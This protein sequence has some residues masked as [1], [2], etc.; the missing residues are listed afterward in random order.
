MSLATLSPRMRLN[1][2]IADA[3]IL[4]LLVAGIG[5]LAIL[6]Q[7]L[8]MP[9][10]D[11]AWLLTVADRMLDGQRLYVDVIETNP[12]ASVYLYWPAA[13]L[14]RILP[15]RAEV[16]VDAMVLAAI[17]GSLWFCAGT[18]RALPNF[19][20][21]EHRRMLVST[22]AIL[23]LLPAAC[24][25]ERE[26]IALI[27]VLPCLC[28]AT[29]RGHAMDI[30]W[31]RIIVT[32]LCG[33]LA[34]VIKPHFALALAPVWLLVSLTRA[35]WRL[36]FAP[37]V[38][39]AG[40]V[41]VAYATETLIVHP[42]FWSGMMPM[43]AAVYLPI[44]YPP[45]A[46][47][48]QFRDLMVGFAGLLT[49]SAW[50]GWKGRTDI[51]TLAGLAGI[52]FMAATILQGKGMPYH[53]YPPM[54]LALLV[55]LNVA[56]PRPG[57]GPAATSLLAIALS[58]FCWTWFNAGFDMR[59]L[60]APV[61]SAAPH[62]RVL[63]LGYDFSAGPPVARAAG[64][65]YIGSVASQW[66]ADNVHWLLEGPIAPDERAR[67]EA[68]EMRDRDLFVADLQTKPDVLLV[69]R[70]PQDWLDWARRDPRF[71]PAF[72]GYRQSGSYNSAGMRNGLT[73]GYDMFVRQTAP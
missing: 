25:G 55:A 65:T 46:F 13:A 62:A 60:I 10:A 27:A 66:T 17:A 67:L 32:G 70:T 23:M 26:H 45:L 44:R 11:I 64:G 73:L 72:A 35:D 30:P 40:T 31:P 28:I 3:A 52:G 33:G 15:L 7:A 5:M 24:F 9:N 56:S 16:I 38:L 22:S 36:L 49:L 48:A 1:S 21:N 37:E 69:Q 59:A 20:A 71:G 58:I 18:L 29:L 19:T 8:V 63:A 4:P 43:L 34:L 54:A 50:R 14:A 68:F 61:K 51:H 6:Q 39:I 53:F 42:A 47:I 57:S 41:A 12:P 2:A